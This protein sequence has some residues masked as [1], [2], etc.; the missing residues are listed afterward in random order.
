MDTRRLIDSFKNAVEGIMYCMKTQRNMRIH[1]IVAILVL[2]AGI[3]FNL[4][5]SD[6]MFLL[7]T[8]ALVIICEM[9]N[10]AVEK[11][12]DTATEEFHPL[13]KISKDVAAGA[14]LISSIAAV[15]VGYIVFSNS[16]IRQGNNIIDRIRNSNFHSV[17][18]IIFIVFI[19]SIIA[20]LAFK[21]GKIVQGGMPSGHAAVAS[22]AATLILLLNRNIIISII[23]LLLA[24]LVMESRLEAK[25]HSGRE[26]VAG[27]VLGT[28]LTLLLYKLV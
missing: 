12:V 16:L 23:G 4:S 17:F 3:F 28:L 6:L 15:A 26:V 8:I 7:L 13:A 5:R 24:A 18:I 2:G 1:I 27:A 25:I 22:A 14:V 21:T 11:A 19:V 10:T 20:K 9:I